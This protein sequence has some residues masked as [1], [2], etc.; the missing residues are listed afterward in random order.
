MKRKFSTLLCVLVGAMALG[1]NVSAK[2][3]T[4]VEFWKD[5]NLNEV[6]RL[7]M[8]TTFATD[9]L[10]LSLS[11]LWK[12]NF[13]KDLNTRPT[14]FYRDGYDDS[15]WGTIPVPGLWD[16]NGYCDPIY[17]NTPYPWDGHFPN[18]PPIVPD[19]HNYVGQY[20][21]NFFLGEEWKGQDIVL[22]IGSATSNVKV[23]VNGK[24]VGYSEDSK[25]EA[26]F[27]ITK[28]VKLGEN[29]IALEIF[30][31]CDGTYVECQDF[32][33][34]A[35]IARDIYVFSR[36]KQRIENIHVSG[37]ADGRYSIVAETTSGVTKVRWQIVDAAGEIAASGDASVNV[38]DKSE[39]GLSC[40]RVEG[41]LPAAKLWTAE[42]PNLYTLELIALNK[43]GVETQTASLKF[44]FRTVEISG[45]QLL[46]N[47]QP[48]L[49]KG[50]N[51]HEMN[52]YKG[53]VVS[54]ADMERDILIMKQLNFNAVRT[55]HYPDDPLWY[56]LCDKYGLYVVD[57]ANI[58]GHGMGYGP[59]ALAK[60]P[61]YHKTIVERVQRMVQRDYNHP[62]VI[63]WS[64][65]NETG[66][67]Q[68][69]FDAYDWLKAWDETRPVQYERNVYEKPNHK[70]TDI[71][72]PM[73]W[74][75]KQCE[76]YVKGNP[77]KPLIQCEY[78]HAMG[79]SVGAFKEY[80]DLI[81]KYP[82]YQGGFIWDFVDQAVW[83]P[84]DAE[85][86]GTDHIFAFGGDFNDYDPTN[87]SFNCNGVIA[88][89]RSLH[90]HAF[91]IA[92]QQ[93]SILTS[94]PA[95]QALDGKVDI[96]NENFFIDLSRY[97]LSWTVECDGEAVLS[98]H[99]SEVLA[100]APQNSS[101]VNLGYM[102]ADV[103]DACGGSLDGHDVYLNVRYTLKKKDGILPA[104]SEVA[105]DQICI[106][107]APNVAYV[108][109]VHAF[110][111]ADGE[112]TVSFYGIMPYEGVLAERGDVWKATFD[113]TTGALI[114]YTLNDRP[115]L[116]Q[117]LEPC[118]WRAATENDMGANYRGKKLPESQKLWR[119]A[120]YKA[121]SFTFED[122]GDFVLVT[123]E[124]AP[125]GEAAKIVVTYSIYG[126]G[127]ISVSES[128]KDAGKL[129]DAP[130]LNRFGM[131]LAMPGEF[132]NVEFF[133]NGPFENYSDRN[134]AAL[135]GHYVQR[136][137]DQYHYGYVRPQES[138]TKT[139]LKWF[140]VL[141][142]NGTGLE[143][144]SDAPFSASALP[145][146][147]EQLDCAKSGTRHSLKLKA[148]AF[149]NQRCNGLTWVNFDLVQMGLG[150]VDSWSY[151]PRTEYLVKPQEMTFNYVIRPVEN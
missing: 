104:G 33:R 1:T 87:E 52:A 134:S 128:L 60:N 65:G 68:N 116:S 4:S 142:D 77:D 83:W 94:S 150:G 32:W 105:Y 35:G 16:L 45:G 149:E 57:E 64:L 118:L 56:D 102:A 110:R 97:E 43:K 115:L 41:G 44:G 23:W 5:P 106:A 100:I 24:E 113:K 36:A 107:S 76:N 140:R 54:P 111:I 141:N 34:Y 122:K 20:R 26:R 112:S 147:T 27:D 11:G 48:V 49:I 133:G 95:E 22:H 125:I 3:K 92:Y 38:K 126:D 81:R 61:D 46:V 88:S 124:Y 139:Q 136:V 146:S 85:K 109:E 59:E 120:E 137:E 78:A 98:G 39:N 132:S 71:V 7:P 148:I 70:G 17:V 2:E 69:F 131:R 93:R 62:S 82:H 130:I 63:I 67:G 19:E 86:Y 129:A 47:G 42:T 10:K 30:R 117:P 15:Q 96:F 21:H 29:T 138:G 18:T 143:I 91:E 121:V 13:N 79:N 114:S 74:D 6:N 75:Y 144:S 14:D 25:L 51:R 127:A 108:P 151:L 40:A 119:D 8:T 73:Y 58:E 135:M 145:F 80:W 28:F 50:V 31:W 12:F 99:A 101:K 55:C 37:D 123:T 89:D 66:A 103:V 84:V 90:P 53:Y 72:C 9:G